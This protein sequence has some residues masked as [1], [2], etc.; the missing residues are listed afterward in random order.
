M[1]RRKQ[2][3]SYQVSQVA[4]R[5]S[6]AGVVAAPLTTPWM[7]LK[8]VFPRIMLDLR[9]TASDPALPPDSTHA[10]SLRTHVSKNPIASDEVQ[11]NLREWGNGSVVF[12][13]VVPRTLCIRIRGWCVYEQVVQTL[14]RM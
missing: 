3:Y 10:P 4:A 11:A 14:R 12:A 13:N 8:L 5:G 6:A 1:L 2:L 7:S 9:V